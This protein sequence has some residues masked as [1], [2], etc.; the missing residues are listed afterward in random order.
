MFPRKRLVKRFTSR[1]RGNAHSV[2]MLVASPVGGR[3]AGRRQRFRRWF[4]VRYLLPVAAMAGLCCPV[5]PLSSAYHVRA[6]AALFHDHG[7]LLVKC[8]T[9]D[10]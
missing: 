4:T 7:S 6:A 5:Y 2:A 9:N 8:D 1:F 3:S 10:P